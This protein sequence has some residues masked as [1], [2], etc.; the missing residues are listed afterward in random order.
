VV[1]RICTEGGSGEKENVKTLRYKI[2]KNPMVIL[3]RRSVSRT[4]VTAFNDG[5]P[6]WFSRFILFTH[7]Q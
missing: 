4:E 2:E 7:P 3:K 1:P 6:S 5:F